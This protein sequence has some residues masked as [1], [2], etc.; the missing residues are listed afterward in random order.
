MHANYLSMEGGRGDKASL[1]ST[2][3]SNMNGKKIHLKKVL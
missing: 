1:I 2:N 3:I